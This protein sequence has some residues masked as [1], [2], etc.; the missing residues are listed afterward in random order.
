MKRMVL[1][2]TVALMMAAMLLV[3]AAPAFA[4]SGQ[5]GGSGTHE[6]SDRAPFANDT[7]VGGRG[8]S[9]GSGS[10]GGCGIGPFGNGG[11]GGVYCS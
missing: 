1:V 8:G 6:I 2:L 7:V 11:F 10:G 9:F 4:R 5:V 3:M